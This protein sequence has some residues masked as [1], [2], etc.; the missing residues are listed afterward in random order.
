MRMGYYTSRLKE[1]VERVSEDNSR[2]MLIHF[3]KVAESNEELGK[4][5][6]PNTQAKFP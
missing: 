3:K 2:V 4:E 6:S 5:V 1:E